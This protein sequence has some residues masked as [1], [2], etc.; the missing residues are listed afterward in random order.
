MTFNSAHHQRLERASSLPPSK[1]PKP[2][3]R[4]PFP[5]PPG[6]ILTYNSQRRNSTP[7]WAVSQI[8]SQGKV[9][10][11]VK[12]K[13][14]E[15]KFGMSPFKAETFS[16]DLIKTQKKKKNN[17]K[18][19]E[20]KN[21]GRE[22]SMRWS[23]RL[24]K[25]STQSNKIDEQDKSGVVLLKQSRENKLNSE[26]NK[27][28]ETNI[29]T[30]LRRS[31]SDIKDK[32]QNN[33]REGYRESSSMIIK[34]SDNT[35]NA[36]PEENKRE[37]NSSKDFQKIHKT[38]V[39]R[40]FSDLKQTSSVPKV[41]DETDTY[42]GKYTSVRIRNTPK[43]PLKRSISDLKQISRVS[44]N[45]LHISG[46]KEVYNSPIFSFSVP[47]YFKKQISYENESENKDKDADI[48]IDGV[49]KVGN[50]IEHV[51]AL[52]WADEHDNTEFGGDKENLSVNVI[53]ELEEKDN[54]KNY[55]SILKR[56]GK[57]RTNIKHVE[58]L[59]NIGDDEDSR[60]RY[61]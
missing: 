56:P 41:T 21:K 43:T 4:P 28:A 5:S 51:S 52:K 31:F 50:V 35:N 27:I 38:K 46:L 53:K 15:L 24:P 26:E 11:Q 25:F 22:N 45:I 40:S 6:S 59:D 36:Y 10:S 48:V 17:Q 3:K 61:F 39:R 33:K 8:Q 14:M 9:F 7:G 1:P 23:F 20:S 58:F 12:S 49:N 47:E 44:K 18:G 13:K 37:E 19:D 60:V 2:P 55:G 54:N 30:K 57:K 29:K 16:S 32:S 34:L 42:T